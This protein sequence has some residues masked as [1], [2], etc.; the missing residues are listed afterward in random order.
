MSEENNCENSD[1]C[2][3]ALMIVSLLTLAVI[4]ACFWLVGQ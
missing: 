4:T 3:D 2:A 1:S